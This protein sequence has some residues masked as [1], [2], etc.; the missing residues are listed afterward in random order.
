MNSIKEMT[1]AIAPLDQWAYNCHQASLALVQSD[2]IGEFAR[3]ARGWANGPVGQHSWVVVGH[4]PYDRNARIVDPT[5]WSYRDDVE[6]IWVGSA[7][8]RQHVPHGAGSIWDWGQPEAVTDEVVELEFKTPPSKACRQFLDLLGPL[9]SHGWKVLA[10]APVEGWPANE[11]LPAINDTIGQVVPIDII[12][13]TTDLNPGGLYLAE[14]PV[15]EG[16]SKCLP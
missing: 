8:E 5:L 15:R 1:D 6:G 10:H 7:K 16:V 13:M 2:A 11:I 4:D 14:P 3:V 9:D 12:G